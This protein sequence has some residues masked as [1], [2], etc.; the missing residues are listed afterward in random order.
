MDTPETVGGDLVSQR[1]EAPIGLPTTNWD[2]HSDLHQSS[3]QVFNYYPNLFFEFLRIKFHSV[4]ADFLR[5]VF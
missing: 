5:V 1:G 4:S 3:Q 2:Y